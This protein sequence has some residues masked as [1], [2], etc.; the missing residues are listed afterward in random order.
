MEQQRNMEDILDNFEEFCDNFEFSAA[1]RFSGID[2]DSREPINNAEV[3]RVTPTVVREVDDGG[4]EGVKFR[5]PPID[6]QASEI[7]ES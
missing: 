3:Q 5:V 6:V 1:K 2:N 4:T 7:T